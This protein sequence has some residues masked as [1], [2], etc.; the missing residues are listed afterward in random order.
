MPKIEGPKDN[1]QKKLI[2][3]DQGWS[4]LYDSRP[5][6]L[7]KTT[8]WSDLENLPK[9]QLD[10]DTKESTPEQPKVT[11]SN[12]DRSAIEQSLGKPLTDEQC[13]AIA[14]S[15]KLL[16]SY[17]YKTN[18]QKNA[19]RSEKDQLLADTFG[20]LT[21]EEAGLEK[22]IM[23]GIKT[24]HLPFE[25]NQAMILA[26]L[27]KRKAEQA[28]KTEEL[29]EQGERRATETLPDISSERTDDITQK[30][31]PAETPTPT[32]AAAKPKSGFFSRFRKK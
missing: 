16:D 29:I 30:I 9:S 17:I 6:A 21:E 23:E 8:S 22:V 24:N 18:L 3:E 1:G 25:V 14:H 20:V 26:R 13:E 28:K 5:P 32:D 2:Y 19:Q 31:K 11:L 27:E 10:T 12:E 7:G 15:K 4:S